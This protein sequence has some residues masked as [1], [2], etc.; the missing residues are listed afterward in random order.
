M[1]GGVVADATRSNARVIDGTCDMDGN[2]PVYQRESGALD[3]PLTCT[4]FDLDP[5]KWTTF[6]II[7]P[8]PSGA[9]H[10][11]ALSRRASVSDL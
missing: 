3:G 5:K 8:C 7:W 11:K 4:S 6:E 10:A 2:A 9:R 1:L